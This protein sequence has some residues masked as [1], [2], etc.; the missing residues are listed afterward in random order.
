MPCMT[1]GLERRY[2]LSPA[3]DRSN[4]DDIMLQNWIAVN[5]MILPA[6]FVSLLLC[7]SWSR[8]VRG[9]W[10]SKRKVFVL[11]MIILAVFVAANVGFLILSYR[12]D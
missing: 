5:I 2:G 4:S 7:V 12:R 6:G 10:P 3:A 9:N 11:S 1:K 8:A